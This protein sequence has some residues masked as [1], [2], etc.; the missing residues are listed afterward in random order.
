MMDDAMDDAFMMPGG[1]LL[2]A[3]PGCRL[4]RAQPRVEKTDDKYVVSIA[5][6]GVKPADLTIE[7]HN[8]PCRLVVKGRTVTDAH[9]HFVDYTVG[10]APDADAESATAD[11]ADG[12]VTVSVPKMATPEPARL[13]VSTANVDAAPDAGYKLTVAAPGVAADDLELSIDHEGVLLVKGSTARTRC[14]VMRRYVLPRD[15]DG[16]K[17]HCS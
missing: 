17:A 16:D 15:A 12:M 7:A 2:N 1:A 11:C 10:L 6:P 8:D 9:T 3:I 13:T 14:Q 5:A 4:S